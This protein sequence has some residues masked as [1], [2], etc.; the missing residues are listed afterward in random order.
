MPRA[1]ETSSASDALVLPDYDPDM[2]LDASGGEASDAFDEL[3][4]DEAEEKDSTELELEKAIFGD[5]AGFHQHLKAHG[6]TGDYRKHPVTHQNE[7]EDEAEDDIRDI[8]DADVRFA[9]APITLLSNHS[10]SPSYSSST[11]DPP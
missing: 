3:E 11:L 5:E 4:S 2:K 8:D 9:T 6:L 1:A 7:L 10:S